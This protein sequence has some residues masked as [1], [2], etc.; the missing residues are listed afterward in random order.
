MVRI[1]NAEDSKE[2]FNFLEKHDAANIVKEK[3]C[4]RSLDNSIC[5]ES[6]FFSK[7][8]SKEMLHIDYKK[9]DQDKFKREFKNRIQNEPIECYS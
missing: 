4:F 3:T 1:F 2:T 9:I 8:P 6:A 7:A 5:I